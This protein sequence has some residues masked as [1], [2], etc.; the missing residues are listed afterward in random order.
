M[1]AVRSLVGCAKSTSKK[2]S[3]SRT[4]VLTFGMEV[5]R[6][7]VWVETPAGTPSWPALVMEWRRTLDGEWEARI[8]V[9]TKSN[10]HP[11]YYDTMTLRWTPAASLRPLSG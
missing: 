11:T 7:H 5:A 1:G 4:H 8:A 6:P 9:L 2:A 10:A 3:S